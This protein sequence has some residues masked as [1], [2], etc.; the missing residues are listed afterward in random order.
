MIMSTLTVQLVD[1]VVT[2]IIRSE[3]LQPQQKKFS[4]GLV[5]CCFT[6]GVQRF[7]KDIYIY[8]YICIACSRMVSC[9]VSQ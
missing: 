6:F 2:F 9:I 3:V 5:L 8:I 1:D 4:K 7:S